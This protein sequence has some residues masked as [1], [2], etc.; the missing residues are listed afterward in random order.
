[1]DERRRKKLRRL[2]RAVLESGQRDIQVLVQNELRL[3]GQIMAKREGPAPK[4]PH[5][6]TK[7]AWMAAVLAILLLASMPCFTDWDRDRKIETFSEEILGVLMPVGKT[8]RACVM[9]KQGC[10]TVLTI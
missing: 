9:R 4:R 3:L 7:S 10:R 2:L 5:G 8:T 1:M 6:H